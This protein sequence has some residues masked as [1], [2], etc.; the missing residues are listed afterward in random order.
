MRINIDTD[1]NKIRPPTIVLNGGT[2]LITNQT[3][4]VP[5]TLSIRKIKATSCA[6]AYFGAIVKI[7]KGIGKIITHN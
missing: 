1:N 7:M 2:S 3:H 6:G 4:V 5:N